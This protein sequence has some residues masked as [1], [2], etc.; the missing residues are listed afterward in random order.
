MSTLPVWAV[1]LLT[2]SGAALALVA[3]LAVGHQN[4]QLVFYCLGLALIIDGVDGT[5]AR[6]I[7]VK[8]RL[9]WFDGAA[10]D[11][12]VDY[13]TYVFVPAMVIAN[14]GL[15]AEPA[16]TAAGIVVAVVGALYFADKR[17]KT[18]D[19]G[20]RG[21]PA[22]WN[23]LAFLLMV[24]RPPEPVSFIAVG[25]C[26][27]LTFSPIEFIHPVRVE[28]LRLLT[29]AVTFAWAV[30]AILT[31]IDDLKPGTLV[32]VALGAASLY[33]GLIGAILQ[34]LRPKSGP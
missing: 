4:W 18:A 30:L 17:M 15:F 31:V 28:R 26:A 24:Y 9:P 13:A 29:T 20:F 3:A 19:K 25:L 10:L 23:T 5:I 11:F 2:A 12:V 14:G 8:E 22:I 27:G 34:L 21:F 6:R 1:H 7:Q 33:L 16:A 32:L